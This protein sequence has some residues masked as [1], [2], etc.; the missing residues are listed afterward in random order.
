MCYAFF[1]RTVG[2]YHLRR[3]KEGGGKRSSLNF[4]VMFCGD[5]LPFFFTDELRRLVVLNKPGEYNNVTNQLQCAK[6]LQ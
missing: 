4:V 1:S 5:H 6:C 2:C 3:E